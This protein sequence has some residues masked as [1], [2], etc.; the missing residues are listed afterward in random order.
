MKIALRYFSGTGNS[1]RIADECKKE[2]EKHA[3]AVE[4]S[5]VTKN[6]QLPDDAQWIGLVFPV[7]AFGIPRVCKRYL[8][9]LGTSREI[10]KAFV[11]VTA[12]EK[13][14]SGFSIRECQDLLRRKN[15]EMMYSAV[16]QMPIN[17][18]TFMPLQP[19]EEV[20]AL[21]EDGVREAA[22]VANEIMAGRTLVHRCKRPDSYGLVRFYFEYLSFKLFGIRFLWRLFSVTSKCNGCGK[23]AKICPTRS[24]AMTEG[25]PKWYSTCEQCM[26]CVNACPNGA[27]F[28]KY[29]VKDQGKRRYLE[30]TFQPVLE[31]KQG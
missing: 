19:P 20:G 27:I 25:K 26:R 14:E 7:Y 9:S 3:N 12:G 4:F 28:Q 5:S 11:I 22:R 23:C 29:G 16:I 17:W 6:V 30:P 21:I 18:V 15:I 31:E 1:K 10:K 24:I 8:K 2:F 13:D